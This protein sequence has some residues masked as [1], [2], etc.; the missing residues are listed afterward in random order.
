M[1]YAQVP[2]RARRWLRGRR[3]QRRLVKHPLRPGMR[4]LEGRARYGRFLR[5]L[6]SVEVTGQKLPNLRGRRR[7]A[8]GFGEP[9]GC[10]LATL[11]RRLSVLSVL[12]ARDRIV[13]NRGRTRP[14]HVN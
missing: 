11:F 13:G 3:N 7:C 4:H 14:R 1:D 8:L 6:L 5:G 12:E 2:R 10:W 9:A